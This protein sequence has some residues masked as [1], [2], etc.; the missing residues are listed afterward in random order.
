[1]TTITGPEKGQ[2]KEITVSETKTNRIIVGLSW[3]PLQ[4]EALEKLGKYDNPENNVSFD[5]I[6]RT[7]KAFTKPDKI[8][9][10][11]ASA[12]YDIVQIIGHSFYLKRSKKS[13]DLDGREINFTHY[14]LDLHGYIY[15]N[16]NNFLHELGPF[17]L[18]S[19]DDSGKAYHSGEDDNGLGG[20]DDERIAIE[21]KGLPNNYK[22]IIFAVKSD[23][24]HTLDEIPNAEIR[25]AD[26][27]TEEDYLKVKI[28][29]S[30]QQK[31][32]YIFCHLYKDGEQWNVRNISE[33]ADFEI[34]TNNLKEYL[35]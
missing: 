3:D 34:N 27:K 16:N 22:H 13:E 31:E 24:K 20:Y 35:V 4:S 12:A 30:E 33:Y 10:N 32:A 23:S 6:G 19:M 11:A 5:S 25:I 7:A 14:D 26:G 29:C 8:V 28:G 2:T 18:D 17:V 15:D 1:M 9:K 21:T